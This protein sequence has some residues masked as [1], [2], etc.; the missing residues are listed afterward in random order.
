VE[1]LHARF[2]ALALA[3]ASAPP[4]VRAEIRDFS[5][6]IEEKTRDFVGRT[7]VFDAFERFAAVNPR[8]YFFIRGDPGI[9]KSA[10]MA[11]L[12]KEQACI[13]HFNMR[14]EGINRPEL[15]LRNVC[16]QIVAACGL[17]HRALP[18]E[19]DSDAGHLRALLSEATD[20]LGP[21]KRLLVVVD[22]L[23]EVDEGGHTADGNTLLM[24]LTLPHG[25]YVIATARRMALRLRVDCEQET[26]VLEPRSD[27]N[28]EDVTA[29]VRRWS[30]GRVSD[31]DDLVDTLITKSE[32]NFN[33]LRHVLPEIDHG[34]YRG[35]D[36]VNLPAGLIGYYE[37]HWRRMRGRAEEAWFE[38][39]LPVLVALTVARKPISVD[40][41]ARLTGI[42]QRS[43]IRSR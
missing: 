30:A 14:A 19:A 42:G 15:F 28:L 20:R 2:G 4:E 31:E 41:M 24:P 9:G 37:D 35:F 22:A 12:V 13:H 36:P 29:F 1:L 27:E 23:D 6:L 10:L 8:G 39:R 3:F 16:A 5:D 17:P 25:A 38:Y 7:F 11:Q 18:I 21:G 34:D 32:G 33:Y 43:R 40:L 26:L